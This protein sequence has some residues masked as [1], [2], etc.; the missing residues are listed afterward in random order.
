MTRRELLQWGMLSAAPLS[1]LLAEA[2]RATLKIRG[3]EA[4]VIR[5]G[6]RRDI[7]CARIET[8]EGLHGWGEGTTPPNVQPV[9]AQI[10]SFEKLL[11]GQSAWEMEKLWRRMYILGENTLG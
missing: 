11:V 4:H 1:P 2:D 3:V 7:V 5:I 10:R 6:A 8:E 9:V